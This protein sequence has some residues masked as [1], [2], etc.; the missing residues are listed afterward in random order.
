MTPYAGE[1]GFRN[2]FKKK[3]TL[4]S[5]KKKK[6]RIIIIHKP[7]CSISFPF[8]TSFS[9]FPLSSSSAI[10]LIFIALSSSLSFSPICFSAVASLEKK[11]LLFLSNLFNQ[12]L[13]YYTCHIKENK[14][15]KRER[16]ERERGERERERGLTEWHPQQRHR[17]ALIF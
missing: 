14:R 7:F 9:F 5:Q 4:K 1:E 12:A 13:S 3:S 11:D 15:E 8:S 6:K 10:E 16:R 17:T 2:D